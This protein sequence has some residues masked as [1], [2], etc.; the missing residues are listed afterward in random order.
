MDWYEKNIEIEV[1][2]V[3]KLLRDNG[4]NTE[5][6]CGHKKYVQCQYWNDGFI[7]E[8]DYLLFN[9]GFKNY[10]IIVDLK[11]DE[12]HIFTT[13]NIEFKNLNE[14]KIE[15]KMEEQEQPKTI[16]WYE[17][18]VKELRDIRKIY[19]E[20]YG[21]NGKDAYFPDLIKEKLVDRDIKN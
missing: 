7:R 9:N 12:G 21:D 15:D 18:Q 14:L 4:I 16:E 5:C 2:D 13:M 6:S 3:V 8:V 19:L 11:R 17:A 10:N 20:L 1:R